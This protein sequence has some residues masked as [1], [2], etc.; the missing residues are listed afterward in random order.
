MNNCE[1]VSMIC[2]HQLSGVIWIGLIFSSFLNFFQCKF[3]T[4]LE[5]K[6]KRLQERTD[7]LEA[8]T[9]QVAEEIIIPQAEFVEEETI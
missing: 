6:M 7:L 2:R 5:K 1:G 8:L 9:E 3:R 4:K